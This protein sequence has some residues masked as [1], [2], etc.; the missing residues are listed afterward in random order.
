MPQGTHLARGIKRG[1]ALARPLLNYKLTTEICLTN[2]VTFRTVTIIRH[3]QRSQNGNGGV[4]N[5]DGEQLEIASGNLAGDRQT[6]YPNGGE[7]DNNVKC[8][9][10]HKVSEL[11]F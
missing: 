9:V 6:D 7:D 1:R 2:E 11:Y 8:G 4:A 10:F 5:Y 3:R